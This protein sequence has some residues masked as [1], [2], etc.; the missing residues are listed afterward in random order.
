LARRTVVIDMALAPSLPR[1]VTRE[2][3]AR[4]KFRSTRDA[5]VR[6]PCRMPDCH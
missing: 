6:A 5:N 4:R 3:V 1:P 2:V